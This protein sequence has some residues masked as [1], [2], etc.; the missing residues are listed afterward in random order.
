LT[1]AVEVRAVQNSAL[2]SS[3]FLRHVVGML[4]LVPWIAALS[5]LLLACG[6]LYVGMKA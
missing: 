1:A 3:M 5:L 4:H 6:A 2:A